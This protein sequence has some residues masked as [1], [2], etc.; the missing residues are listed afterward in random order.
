MGNELTIR[1]G[2]SVRVARVKLGLSQE[3]L[4]ALC[5]LSRTYVG[6][7]ER[8]DVSP[9]ITTLDKI[10]KALD[11]KISSLLGDSGA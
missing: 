4:A 6:E 5:E 8:G 3:G 10:A 7:V 11:T 9:S 2:R 1:I